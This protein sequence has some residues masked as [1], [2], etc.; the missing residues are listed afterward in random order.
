M[1]NRSWLLSS[2]RKLIFNNKIKLQLRLV[3]KLWPVIQFKDVPF[4]CP[5]PKNSAEQGANN[6]LSLI[7]CPLLL[8]T[9]LYCLWF[10]WEGNWGRAETEGSES[11]AWLVF[12]S[13]IIDVLRVGKTLKCYFDSF[14]KY[15]VAFWRQSFSEL[16]TSTLPYSCKCVSLLS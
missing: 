16:E 7:V 11:V 13:P 10:P 3:P 6:A 9:W 1:Q 4:E 15:I 14:T 12:L 5:C 2:I 8:P